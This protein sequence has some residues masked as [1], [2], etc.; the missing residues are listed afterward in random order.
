MKTIGTINIAPTNEGMARTIAYLFIRHT[1]AD[2]NQFGD[3]WNLT[4]DEEQALFQAWNHIDK[5]HEGYQAIGM[6]FY[7]MPRT[8]IKKTILKAYAQAKANV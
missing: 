8:A 7:D 4:K 3:Y 5:I 1:G 2:I 6:S